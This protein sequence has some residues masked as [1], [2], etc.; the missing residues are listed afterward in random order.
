MQDGLAPLGAD[1]RSRSQLATGQSRLLRP[2]PSSCEGLDA[3]CR[4]L[5]VAG[6]SPLSNRVA[7]SGAVLCLSHDCATLSLTTTLSPSDHI[8]DGPRQRYVIEF[9]AVIS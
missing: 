2:G 1:T 5:A 6:V 7:T 3:T 9:S 4:F 8:Y